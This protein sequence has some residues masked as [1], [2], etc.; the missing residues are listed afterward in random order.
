LV[1]AQVLGYALSKFIGIRFNSGKGLKNKDTNIILFIFLAEIALL[2]FALVPTNYKFL[3]LFL[4]GL[5]LGMIWGLVFSYIEGRTVTELLA[6]ILSSSF[7]LASGF[8]KSVG[9]FLMNEYA[10]SPYWMPFYTGFLFFIPLLLGVWLIEKVP[11]RSEADIQNRCK[12]E[13][14]T[15]E[16]R[17]RV[18]AGLAPGLIALIILLFLMTAFR[19]LRD[20]FSAEFWVELGYGDSAAV[21]TQTELFITI[22]ILGLLGLFILIKDNL[23]ALGIMQIMMV[24]GLLI[25]LISTVLYQY[26]AAISAFVWMILSGLGV[27]MAYISLGGSIIFERIISTFKFKG[28][29]A[30]LIYLADAFGY[31]GSVVL[32]L[33]KEVFYRDTS[34]FTYFTQMIYLVSG[35]GMVAAIFSFFYFRMRYKRTA[36]F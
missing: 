6:A 21:F 10:V 26:F 19:D 20:N 2:G 22:G 1:I 3:F 25:L 28:N 33:I 13:P 15:K 4:N 31:L 16:D 35:V 17:R 27:Y 18:F 30:Y 14:M 32:L 34:F 9:K 12:R 8:T 11:P 36:N 7:I 5:P 24:V 23:A 29:A